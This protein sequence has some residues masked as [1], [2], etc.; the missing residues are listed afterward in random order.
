ME[1]TNELYQ[2]GIWYTILC[3][4]CLH[5]LYWDEEF[6]DVKVFT[7]IATCLTLLSG[8]VVMA[9]TVWKQRHIHTACILVSLSLTLASVSFSAWIAGFSTEYQLF[10]DSFNRSTLVFPYSLFLFSFGTGLN[11]FIAIYQAVIL[12]RVWLSVTTHRGEVNIP[13][14]DNNAFELPAI[15]EDIPEMNEPMTHI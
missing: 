5:Q 15:R 2:L 11:V 13:S 4:E 7:L 9:T 10:E 3:D 14:I 6:I 12:I 1:N 8:V